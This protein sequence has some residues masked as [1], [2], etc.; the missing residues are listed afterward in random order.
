MG[1]N[2][3][4]VGESVARRT[5]LGDDGN[6]MPADGNAFPVFTLGWMFGAIGGCRRGA[7]W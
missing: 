5:M 3:V 6:L 1:G 2:A 4:S 7:T